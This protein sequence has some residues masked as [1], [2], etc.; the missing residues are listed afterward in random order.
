MGWRAGHKR[1]CKLLGKERRR[2]KAAV[3][4]EHQAEAQQQGSA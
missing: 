4:G 2:H 1:V 3:A